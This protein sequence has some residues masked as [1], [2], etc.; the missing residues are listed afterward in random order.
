MKMFLQ[1][2]YMT[3]SKIKIFVHK[4]CKIFNAGKVV[5]ALE[6]ICGVVNF[7]IYVDVLSCNIHYS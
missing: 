1:Q 4:A 6:V 7:F 2:D 5:S 3:S